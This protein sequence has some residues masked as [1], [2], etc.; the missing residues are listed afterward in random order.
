[1]YTNILGTGPGVVL[2]DWLAPTD[3][4]TM[5]RISEFTEKANYT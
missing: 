5:D 4:L 3:L 1:M 2:F